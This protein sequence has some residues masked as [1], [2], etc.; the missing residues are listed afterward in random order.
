MIV[1]NNTDTAPNKNIAVCVVFVVAVAVAANTTIIIL[2]LPSHQIDCIPLSTDVFCLFYAV[3][4][5]WFWCICL[6]FL[7]SNY[8]LLM[9]FI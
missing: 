3:R 4:T 2:L 5:Y 7:F 6:F 8:N 9:Y 1:N